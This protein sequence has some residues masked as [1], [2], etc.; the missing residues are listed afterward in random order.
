[1][2]IFHGARSAVCF[3]A[4][5]TGN[6]AFAEVTAQQVWDS[7][8]S[9]MDAYG[10]N[11]VTVGSETMSGNTLTVTDLGI[12][13]N[14]GTTEAK[15][16][17][18]NITLTEN[19]DG[20]VSVTMSDSY[21]ITISEPGDADQNRVVVL[22]KTAG[23]KL[24]VMGDPDN[25]TYD[26]AAARYTISI[27]EAV[28]KGVAIPVE[29]AVNLN[30][31]AG[32]YQMQV[33]DLRQI[34]Y[35]MTAGS[36]D[37]LLDAKDGADTVTMS[38]QST[39]LAMQGRL[40]MP[41][42]MNSDKPEEMFANGMMFNGSYTIARSAYLF[43]VQNSGD[44]MNGTVSVGKSEVM[45]SLD[46]TM[47]AYD[48]GINDIAVS[49]NSQ[50]LPFP[51]NVAL[52]DTVFGFS[53]PLAKT[54]EPAPF[55][56]RIGLTDLTVNDEIWGLID[57]GSQL[58]HDPA[59]I[60]IDVTGTGKLFADMMDPAQAESMATGKTPP[61]ELNTL[62]L[63][64]LKLAIAGALITGDGAFTFDNT[65]LTTFEGFPRPEGTLNLQ[66]DGINGLMDKLVAMGL[67]PEQQIMGAR[68][69]MGMF[70]TVVGDDKLTSTVVVNPAGQVMVNGQRIK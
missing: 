5:L 1:M 27:D 13:F 47:M 31:L 33:G 62:N 12:D 42:V 54:D 16:T 14:D 4:L 30:D 28:E 67:V 21:P 2:T 39:D 9:Q 6:A 53:M 23:M 58:P 3:V 24:D 32:T 57:P 38:G 36:L 10:Q 69:M 7:W 52:A 20:T 61:G 29:A 18:P 51:V 8:K 48:V 37:M 55:S 40:A 50:N 56:T 34:N 70:A 59:T 49:A 17:I 19:G 64:T 63:N 65:D 66:A 68:M 15:G 60:Q 45:G 44:S 43:D 22:L 41:L 11:A 35:D 26:F 25:M 46:K